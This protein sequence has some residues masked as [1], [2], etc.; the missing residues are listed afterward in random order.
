MT[1]PS[2]RHLWSSSLALTMLLLVTSSCSAEQSAQNPSEQEPSAQDSDSSPPAEQRSSPSS[3]AVG[4]ED[5]EE[6]AEA[7]TEV[8]E[9]EPSIR[10]VE[11]ADLEWTEWVNEV[12]LIPAEGSDGPE[13]E[14]SEEIHYADAD[15][16]GHEDALVS[17]GWTDDRGFEDIWYIWAWD[18]DTESAYQAGGP[19]A[20]AANCG[21]HVE[22]VSAGEDHFVIEEHLWPQ[23]ADHDCASTPSIQVT[24]HLVLEDD[25]PVMI[26][27]VRA[28]GGMCPQIL[29]TD[30]LWPVEDFEFRTS[31]EEA[32]GLV[33]DPAPTAFA[34]ADVWSRLW[35]HYPNWM[36]VHLA[37]MNP[38]D[39][40]PVLEGGYTPCGWVYLEEDTRPVPHDPYPPED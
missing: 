28:H 31:P 21:D 11:F 19:V 13:F 40:P 6:E 14:V 15:G 34:E 10:D 25:W 20:R 12:V 32:A 17:L 2:P 30:D 26:S 9:E 18:P 8:E 33:G 5:P 7:V 37:Y 24:R 3:A 38:A 22:S 29:G 39:G 27:P 4:A 1:G 36:L 35:L 16:D 23:N